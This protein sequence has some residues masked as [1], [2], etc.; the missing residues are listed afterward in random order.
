MKMKK[1][2]SL[3]LIAVLLITLLTGCKKENEEE[4]KLSASVTLLTDTEGNINSALNESARMGLEDAESNLGIEGRNIK[5]SSEEDIQDNIDILVQGGKTDIIIG[6]GERFGNIIATSAKKYPEQN[7]A[8]IDSSGI[9]DIPKNVVSISFDNERTGF[10]AGFIAGKMTSKG[11]VAIVDSKSESYADGFEKG[12]KSANEK[13]K[14]VL[15]RSANIYTNPESAKTAVNDCEYYGADVIFSSLA[16]DS[17]SAINE[18]EKDLTKVIAINKDQYS[19]SKEKVIA[20]IIRSYE[21]A[22]YDIS[23][24]AN[25]PDSFKGGQDIRYNSKDSGTVLSPSTENTVPPDV[26]MRLDKALKENYN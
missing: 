23:V 6:A 25:D 5:C 8:V 15:I 20:S 7:F 9:E 2:I 10:M 11:R 17:V 24:M 4:R 3:L 16:D 21:K 14:E 19:Y 26:I 13:I 18:A 1:S 12:A 22:V